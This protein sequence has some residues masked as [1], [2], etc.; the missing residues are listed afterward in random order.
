MAER[1]A[2]TRPRAARSAREMDHEM[3]AV[4]TADRSTLLEAPLLHRLG[5]VSHETHQ[6]PITGE[7]RGR[8]GG[9]QGDLRACTVHTC[10][11]HQPMHPGTA[12]RC[13]SHAST[14]RS[15]A[16]HEHVPWV[17]QSLSLSLA[18]F[19][20]HALSIPPTPDCQSSR[21]ARFPSTPFLSAPVV[22]G[23]ASSSSAISTSKRP[24]SAGEGPKRSCGGNS[25]AGIV[26]DVCLCTMRSQTACATGSVICPTACSIWQCEWNSPALVHATADRPLTSSS[27]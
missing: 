14:L 19:S 7:R 20:I 1:S 23:P 16:S 17:M 6:G 24:A 15:A 2:E 18:C 12:N 27:S 9:G 4:C 8:H 3:H 26:R 5:H 21:P 25:A 22:K 10:V 11:E 13:A